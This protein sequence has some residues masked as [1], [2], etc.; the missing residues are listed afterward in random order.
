MGY[1]VKGI[2]KL[3]D[4]APANNAEIEFISR[5]NF[6]PLVREL[7]SNIRCSATGSYDVTLEYGEYAVVVYPGGT[8]PA[9]LGT[10]ILAADTVAGHDLP[11]LLQQE[12]WQPATPEYVQQIQVW[13]SQADK[14][15]QDAKQSADDA[16]LTLSSAVKKDALTS[17]SGEL[18]PAAAWSGVPAHSDAE[19][20]GPM[21]EQAVALAAR[22]KFLREEVARLS[23][24]ARTSTYSR[25]GNGPLIIAHRS[26]GVGTENSIMNYQ[27][28][29]ESGMY[30]GIELDMCISAD[31][32]LYNFHDRDVSRLTNGTGMF[33]ELNSSYI[34]TLRYE[35]TEG[36]SI[37]GDPIPRL[38]DVLR[39]A[40][41]FGC[42]V[43]AEIKFLRKDGSSDRLTDVHIMID[44]LKEAGVFEKSFLGAFDL[45]YLTTAVKYDKLTSVVRYVYP[46]TT[47]GVDEVAE[48]NS[49]GFSIASIETQEFTKSV[50]DYIKSKG[51]IPGVWTP[52]DP[53]QQEAAMRSGARIINS[54]AWGLGN[55][56]GKK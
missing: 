52:N 24:K 31:G 51:L 34:D 21:N 39:V 22:S 13:L 54:D 50:S 32:V 16:A 42:W 11:T 12:V 45:S 20:G 29:L 9:A 10:I 28:M 41:D 53:M 5:K 27:K 37:A 3:P 4:G 8:Y 1:R 36:T 15:A 25:I 49:N 43:S 35:S 18:D 55:L 56:G 6:S 23:A 48:L 47:S 46:Y 14:Y 26:G 33:Y 40:A 17:F 30:D 19:I 44:A 7:K 2:L 38:S